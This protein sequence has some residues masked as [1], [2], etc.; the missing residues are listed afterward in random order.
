MIIKSNLHTFCFYLINCQFVHYEE[1]KH[2]NFQLK[3]KLCNNIENIYTKRDDDTIRFSIS[4]QFWLKIVFSK[5][6][7]CYE[8]WLVFRLYFSCHVV[9]KIIGCTFSIWSSGSNVSIEIDFTAKQSYLLRCFQIAHS[10]I[11]LLS[12]DGVLSEMAHKV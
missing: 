2:K 12:A 5:M 7:Y 3:N 8:Y 4:Q 10:I 9:T 1:M 6:C 11:N